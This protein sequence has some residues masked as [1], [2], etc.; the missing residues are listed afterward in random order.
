MSPRDDD[1]EGFVASD[2]IDL[3][4]Y[5]AVLIKRKWLILTVTLACLISAGAYEYVRGHPDPLF[6]ARSVLMILPP[7]FKAELTPTH[8]SMD[9]YKNLAKAQDLVQAIVDTLDLKDDRGNPVQISELDGTLSAAVQLSQG[10]PSSSVL[11]LTVST[12][13]TAR[14]PLVDVANTWARIF[15]RRNSGIHSK[16][17]GHSYEFINSQYN[18]ARTRL[19]AL[20]DSLLAF[21]ESYNVEAMELE[22]AAKMPKLAERQ[23]TYVNLTLNLGAQIQELKTLEEQIEVM[24]TDSGLWLGSQELPVESY[25]ADVL[26]PDQNK[27]LD[28]VV[29][30]RDQVIALEQKVRAYKKDH[31]LE[32]LTNEL[33]ARRAA[34][35][36]HLRDYPKMELE[37]EAT[38]DAL[39][40]IGVPIDL[41]GGLSAATQMSPETLWSLMSIQ[42]GHNFFR[43][44]KEFLRRQITR[45]EAEIDSLD[46]LHYKGQQA[47]VHMDKKLLLQQQIHDSLA[48]YY[49]DT[50]K[51]ANDRKVSIHAL[52][53][54]V[55]FE[56]KELMKLGREVKALK[57][58]IARF[59]LLRPRLAE[60]QNLHKITFDKYA[61]LLEDARIAAG[62]QASDVKILAEAVAPVVKPKEG[63]RNT[64]LLVFGIGLLCSIFLAF[65]MEYAER[66][67]ARVAA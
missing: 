46:A 28:A 52:Q 37:S 11:E 39:R 45:L 6:Q 63:G 44:R 31:Q 38:D 22:L 29:D 60:Q 18:S 66:A 4:D 47:L 34:M 36:A 1:D 61:G 50:K 2:E 7:V 5:I 49:S 65:F 67:R 10:S 19:Y 30:S 40:S 58:Q 48:K 20:Q 15:V 64:L 17:I 57:D 55:A 41:N 27:I 53:N 23:T 25:L 14:I 59:R 33:G 16:E 26:T 42:T 51:R 8:F 12:T 43:P 62:S 3:V 56:K 9:V 21:D 32:F 24:E 54:R 13:D 35:E